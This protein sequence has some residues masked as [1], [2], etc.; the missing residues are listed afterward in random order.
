MDALALLLYVVFGVVAF[1]WRTWLQWRRTGDTGLRIHATVGTLQWWAK[2]AFVAA[3]LAG[4]AA[5]VTGLLGLEPL[6]VLDGPTFH[7]VGTLLTVVGIAATAMAQWQMGNS[8]RIGVDPSE[9]TG[10]VTEGVFGHIRNPIFTAMVLTAAGFTLM[11]GN[12]VAVAGFAALVVALEV[13]VRFVE[14]PYLARTHGEAYARY[15]TAAGRFLPRVG[16][17][18]ARG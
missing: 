6:D 16:R 12:L 8:W 10:L 2:L 15:A 18:P 13:Q 3:I 9:R 5:P 1:G 4:V 17:T 14:E 7:V 11:V